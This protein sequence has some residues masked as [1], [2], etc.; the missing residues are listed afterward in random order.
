MG[1]F[2]TIYTDLFRYIHKTIINK[3]V[4][5]YTLNVIQG[6]FIILPGMSL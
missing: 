3:E 4:V 6:D 1:A 2:K 5:K